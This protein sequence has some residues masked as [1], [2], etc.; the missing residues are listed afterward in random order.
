MQQIRRVIVAWTEYGEIQKS[1]KIA[2]SENSSEG[3]HH[4]GHI[5]TSRFWS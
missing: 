2:D 3:R 5:H 4:F 1:E